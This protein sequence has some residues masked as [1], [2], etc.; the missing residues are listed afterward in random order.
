MSGVHG[1]GTQTVPQWQD[2]MDC[3]SKTR[4]ILQLGAR[5]RRTGSQAHLWPLYGQGAAGEA[6]L[7]LCGA[8]QLHYDWTVVCNSLIWPVALLQK[9]EAGGL[10]ANYDN[11]YELP[12]NGKFW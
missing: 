5:T 2:A 9:E 4:H 6:I 1:A 11:C 12:Y 7:Q 10:Y 3:Q 8:E